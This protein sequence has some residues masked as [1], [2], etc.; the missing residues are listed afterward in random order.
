MTLH[1]AQVVVVGGSSGI[2]LAAAKAARQAGAHLTIAGRSQDKLDAAQ[3]ELGDARVVAADIAS[4]TAVNGVFD[5]L[6]HVDHV[7]ISAGTIR[8]GSIV[9]NDLDTLRHIVDERIWGLVHVVR[10]VRPLMTQGTITFTS[11]TLSS[12]PRPGTAMLSAALSAVEAMARALVA[13]FAPVRVNTVTPGLID[14]LLLETAFGEARH[15]MIKDR[16]AALP[17]KRIGTADEV[18]QAILMCMTNVYLNG[19]V[20]HVDGGA[21]FL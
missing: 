5:G 9:E 8:N 6:D 4:E 21:R 16:S 18:A 17:A 3:K 14:T 2:G 13:E 15:A 19:E 1:G 7:V 11:G 10:R 12:R 20:L